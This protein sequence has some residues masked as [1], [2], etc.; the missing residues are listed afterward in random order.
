MSSCKMLPKG[1]KLT[2]VRFVQV[3]QVLKVY[4]LYL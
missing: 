4:F 3:D 2:A 1:D